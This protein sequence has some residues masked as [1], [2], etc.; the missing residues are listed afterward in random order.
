MTLS[1]LKQ[2]KPIVLQ[3]MHF[4]VE[5]KASYDAEELLVRLDASVQQAAQQR[6]FF[7]EQAEYQNT[8]P[9]IKG[10]P[11]DAKVIKQHRQKNEAVMLALQT[12]AKVIR[13][14]ELEDDEMRQDF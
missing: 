1:C 12:A 10:K 2:A 6:L 8:Q 3:M 13:T 5:K 4:L 9:K 11:F 7:I 14:T